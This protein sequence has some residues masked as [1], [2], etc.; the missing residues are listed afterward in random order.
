MERKRKNEMDYFD[1]NPTMRRKVRK[2]TVGHYLSQVDINQSVDN[3]LSELVL[4]DDDDVL[5][6]NSN[7]NHH[8]N[9]DV[10]SVFSNSANEVGPNIE[11]IIDVPDS[12]DIIPSLPQYNIPSD[13]SDEIFNHHGDS[14]D[15]ETS[16][17]EDIDKGELL[18]SKLRQLVINLIN[19]FIVKKN[20]II[21][22]L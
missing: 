15:A 18:A 7:T 12:E 4:P 19:L 10:D 9:A 2:D 5:P 6:E 1:L 21:V 16:D 11:A 13:Y 14:D 22:C 3:F 8:D 20:P 17:E